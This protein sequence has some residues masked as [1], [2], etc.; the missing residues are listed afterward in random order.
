MGRETLHWFR[1]ITPG[2]L[3]AF[4]ALTL[5]SPAL[6]GDYLAGVFHKWE[7]LVVVFCL[8]LGFPYRVFDVRKLFLGE[9]FKK[10]NEN[11]EDKLLVTV[12]RERSLSEN[13]EAF[14]RDDRRLI[15]VFYRVIDND[16]S[17]KVRTAGIYFNGYLTTLGVDIFT[18]GSIAGLLHLIAWASVGGIAQLDWAFGCLAVAISSWVVFRQAIKR[19]LRLSNEQLSYIGN[20]NAD[21]VR[22]SVDAILRNMPPETSSS[23]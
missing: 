8:L 10:I 18:V 1:L 7:G 15:D 3:A 23:P 17:L 12:R 20:F 9:F 11:I 19:H 16:E 2:A 14:L 21:K 13:Q 6:S 5:F 22:E 4:F